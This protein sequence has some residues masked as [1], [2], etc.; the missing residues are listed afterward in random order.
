MCSGG[1]W[2]TVCDDSWGA[3]EAEVVCRQLSFSPE[4]IIY[5]QPVQCMQYYHWYNVYYIGA[6]ARGNAFFGQGVGSIV[7]DDAQCTGSRV[8]LLLVRTL[9]CTTVDTVKTLEWNALVSAHTH[10]LPTI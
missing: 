2:G 8:L 3:A 6:I 1:L 9:Q 7:I 5:H 10:M 4:G